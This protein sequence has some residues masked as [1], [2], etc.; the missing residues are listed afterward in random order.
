M[1]P[2]VSLASYLYVENGSWSGSALRC[3]S[4]E[5]QADH[6]DDG[7][8]KHAKLVDRLVGYTL[9]IIRLST[10]VSARHVEAAYVSQNTSLPH[11]SII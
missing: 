8:C 2:V 4:K 5:R 6:G 11:S 1:S 10:A 7:N 3:L 9:F